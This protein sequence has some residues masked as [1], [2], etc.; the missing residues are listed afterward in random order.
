MSAEPDAAKP[1]TTKPDAAAPDATGPDAAGLEFFEKKIRPVLVKHCYECHSAKSKAIKGALLLDTR[2]GTRKGGESGPSVVPGKI[3]D[4]LLLS[5]LQYDSFEM[6]PKGKLPKAVIA[7]FEQWVKMGA[8]DPREA[9]TVIAKKTID[10]KAAREFWSFR[11]ITKPNLPAVRDAAWPRNDIDRFVLAQLEA[12]NL[13]P[14]GPAEKR[15]LIR[16]A[17]FDLIGLPP[18][19]EE[20]EEF[21]ADTDPKAFEKVVSRLL[22]SP[23]YGERWGRRW[24]DVA[25]YGEDQA[26][27]FKARKYPSGFRYR[28]WVVKS[29][30]DDMPYD[31]FVSLQVAGDLLDGPDRNGRLAALG[32]FALGPVYY[33]DNGEKKKAMAD[34]WDDRIDTLIRGVQGLTVSCARCHDHKFDPISMQDYY[35]IAGVFASTDYKEYPIAPQE[36]LDKKKQADDAVKEQDKKQ[37]DLI[38]VEKKRLTAEAPMENGKKKPLPKKGKEL[39]KLFSD[40]AKADLKTIRAELDKRKKA[41]AAI[42]IPVVHSLIEGKSQDLK[43]YLSGDPEKLGDVAPRGFL[44][45]IAGAET[46]GFKTKG[47]GRL[48]LAAAIASKN[49]PLTARVIVNRVWRG[50]FG[51]GIVRTPSNFGSLGERPTHPQ[52]LDFLASSFIENGWSLKTLHKQ[53]M[54]SAVYRSS[55]EFNA[56]ANEVDPENRLLWRMNRRRLEVEP[57]RDA[58]LAV[59]GQLDRNIGGPSINLASNGNKRR[60]LYG[61]VSRH[62][63]DDVLHLFDFPDPNI[64]I[65]K[66]SET[67]VPLQLLFVLNSE[68]MTSQAKTLSARLMSENMENDAARIERVY[69]LLFG[70]SPTAVETEVG[71]AFV[72]EAKVSTD[73]LSQWEQYALV[74][75]GSNEFTFVD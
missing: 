11:P 12:K 69:Q 16:R 66:R 67:T 61:F 17:T 70:R 10:Y 14:A 27:T 56:A 53:I 26:H 48:E 4:S 18:T 19:P 50:H 64:T 51:R 13:K 40:K 6:P 39:E 28:D 72:G 2:V 3:D 49:N 65:A 29:L 73:G 9:T 35:G 45:V 46:P 47:S 8:P 52:L 55:S 68:F 71:T 59:S 20:I 42:K 24:L 33:A 43:I 31:R 21:L 60:T 5:A 44:R 7:D 32:L 38:G 23:H 30:N 74:L 15:T 58:M 54:L 41:T 22:A 25:R 36:M 1:D 62:K 57:W 37:R 63:L 34:E 75:L